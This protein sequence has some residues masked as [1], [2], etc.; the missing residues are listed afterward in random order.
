MKNI[1][2]KLINIS[3]ECAAVTKNGKNDYHNYSYTQAQ[4]VAKAIN[5]AFTKHRIAST[6]SH[7]VLHFDTTTNKS[8][9]EER[10]VTVKATVTLIDTETGEYVTTTG[11]GSGQ[12]LGDKAVMK[13]ETAALKYA[14]IQAF[15][16]SCCGADPEA[17]LSVDE[18]M[19]GTDV[20]KPRKT[21]QKPASTTVQTCSSCTKEISP[22]IAEYSQRIFNRPLCIA[23]QNRH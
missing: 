7:E 8:G 2:N 19:I 6:V 13:A 22:N 21:I 20:Q 9:K 3:Q 15:N 4:D 5:S 12:D 23:C 10:I 18:R 16:M 17:D 1:T 14:Y 11:L